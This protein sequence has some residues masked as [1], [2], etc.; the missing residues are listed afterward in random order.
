[1]DPSSKQVNPENKASPVSVCF[2][3]C[4]FVCLFVSCLGY[5]QV[6]RYLQQTVSVSLRI[7]VSAHRGTKRPDSVE[8]NSAVIFFSKVSPGIFVMKVK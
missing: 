8:G 4:V 2:F 3:V 7:L 6:S 5:S 1:M